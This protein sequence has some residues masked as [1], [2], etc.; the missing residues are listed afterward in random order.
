MPETTA[1]P[2]RERGGARLYPDA[3]VVP[4]GIGLHPDQADRFRRLAKE[5]G[6]SFSAVVRRALDEWA[7]ENGLTADGGK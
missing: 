3:T 1:R 7:R 2:R 5:R 4:Y 6:V